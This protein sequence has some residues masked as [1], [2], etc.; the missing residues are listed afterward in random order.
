MNKKGGY[1]CLPMIITLHAWVT[2]TA[3]TGAIYYS[4]KIINLS[5]N[6]DESTSGII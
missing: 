6:D 1:T 4:K 5:F 3:T 2:G